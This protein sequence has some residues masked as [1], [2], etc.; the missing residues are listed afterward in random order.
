MDEPCPLKDSNHQSALQNEKPKFGNVCKTHSTAY[1]HRMVRNKR[2]EED[3]L[4][5]TKIKL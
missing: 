3:M 5:N 2:R 4:G 1:R